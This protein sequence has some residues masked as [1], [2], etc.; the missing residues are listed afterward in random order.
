[1]DYDAAYLLSANYMTNIVPQLATFNQGLWKETENITEC[2]RDLAHIQVIGG[3]IFSFKSRHQ[4]S[5]LLLENIN[6]N[7][8]K[9]SD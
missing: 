1:M 6:Y 2:Y 8:P 3:V 5:R 9:Q 4:E 7:G